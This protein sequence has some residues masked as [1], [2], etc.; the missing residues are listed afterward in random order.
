M[1]RVPQRNITNERKREREELIYFKGLAYV[2]VGAHAFE[3]F[4][5]GRRSSEEW[6]LQLESEGRILFPL[7]N[8]SGFLLRP[9]T[10]WR[11]STHSM[12]GH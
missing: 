1:V 5:A 6:L 7:G 10:D 9:S 12:A 4:G 8:R 11:K 3:I 2:I